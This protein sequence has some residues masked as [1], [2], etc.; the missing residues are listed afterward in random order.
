MERR[1]DP[2]P[3]GRVDQVDCSEPNTE[4]TSHGPPPDGCRES[5]SSLFVNPAELTLPS[6]LVR[7]PPAYFVSG[8]ASSSMLQPPNPTSI[9][10]HQHMPLPG[11]FSSPTHGTYPSSGYSEPTSG[12]S[13]QIHPSLA[14]SVDEKLFL[15]QLGDDGSTFGNETGTPSVLTMQDHIELASARYGVGLPRPSNAVRALEQ[16]YSSVSCLSLKTSLRSLIFNVRV[17]ITTTRS[18][19]GT[20]YPSCRHRVR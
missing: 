6:P 3:K 9:A 19:L 13:Y 8:A 16:T 2:R 4:S 17:S 14:C 7:A 10:Q 1:L 15:P 20:Q 11:D 5:S 12:L 18:P